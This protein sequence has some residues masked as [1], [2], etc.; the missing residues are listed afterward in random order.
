MWTQTVTRSEASP[1][2]PSEL[3]RVKFVPITHPQT[4]RERREGWHNFVLDTFVVE[5]SVKAGTKGELYETTKHEVYIRRE[6]SVQGP[7][8][9]LQIRDIVI[10]KY[11][12]VIEERR[13]NAMNLESPSPGKS[14]KRE[15]V[16]IK[17]DKTPSA[18]KS[19]KVIV[20]SP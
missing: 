12:E 1:G 13:I 19:R 15:N 7:L 17:K 20:I 4:A 16:E 6:S 11:R 5:I 10:Q 8:N 9:P 2:E 18:K 3:S 14:S